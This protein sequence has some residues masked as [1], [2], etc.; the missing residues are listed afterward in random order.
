MTLF[1]CPDAIWYGD[2]A[3]PARTVILFIFSSLLFFPSP[4]DSS[5]NLVQKPWI[6]N[7]H[8]YPKVPSSALPVGT[9]SSL[10]RVSLSVLRNKYADPAGGSDHDGDA[11]EDGHGG[12]GDDGHDDGDDDGGVGGRMVRMTKTMKVVMMMM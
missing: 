12:E 8:T 10:W 11:R 5:S 7:Q 1:L 9:L 3:L 6:S 4:G 2:P